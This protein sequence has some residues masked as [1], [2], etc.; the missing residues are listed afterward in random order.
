MTGQE[1]HIDTPARSLDVRVERIEGR[2]N[3]L[4]QSTS[5]SLHNLTGSV[6]A[7][8][9][10]MRDQSK[11]SQEIR[12][13]L[14]GMRAHSEGL[15][16]LSDT[17]NRYIDSRDELFAKHVAENK[18]TADAVVGFNSAIKVISWV[19]GVIAAL[20]AAV[21]GVQIDTVK[22]GVDK[23]ESRIERLERRP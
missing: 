15:A 8:Q 19:F 9:G 23:I 4:E 11:L 1:S 2:Y 3:L 6:Q 21:I 20:S 7:M 10:D 14:A 12:N 5:M 18:V 16:R 13:D 17:I 22:T